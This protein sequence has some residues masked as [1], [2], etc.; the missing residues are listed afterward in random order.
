ME[1][2][3]RLVSLSL[4]SNLGNK[5]DNIQKAIESIQLNVGHIIKKSSVFESEPWGFDSINQFLNCCCIIETKYS[6]VKL[7]DQLKKIEN[8][9]GR[10]NNKKGYN[11][12]IIDIDIIFYGSEVIQTDNLIIPH[13]HFHKR[14]FVLNPLSEISNKI[15]PKTFI[16]VNQFTK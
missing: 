11:D 7:L 12:R 13:P 4:G 8:E 15:D 6:P 16:S 1:G 2:Q 14:N 10:S 3:K 5:P 9:M